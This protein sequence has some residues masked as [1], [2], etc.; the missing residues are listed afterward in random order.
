MTINLDNLSC[1]LY[2]M[3]FEGKKIRII[4]DLTPLM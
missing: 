1:G 3:N 2:F 4:K